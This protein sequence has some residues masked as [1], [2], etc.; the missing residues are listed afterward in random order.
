MTASW[1]VALLIGV[2]GF[3]GTMARY[4]CTSLVSA[5]V[6]TP[7]LP[8]MVVNT[9]GSFAIGV[10]Y[11]LNRERLEDPSIL[12]LTVGVLGG[13][14]TF[15]AFSAETANFL[16]EGQWSTAFLYVGVMVGLGLLFT[17]AGLW[18]SR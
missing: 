7:G 13:F 4:F 10:I 14:T 1:Q 2:G 16:R 6:T 8:T 5:L 17:F 9:V 11:G 18:I 15:S 12:I 3:F